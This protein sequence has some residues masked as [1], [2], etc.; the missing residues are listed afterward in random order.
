MV[1]RFDDITEKI[2]AIKE[3]ALTNK[4]LS[5]TEAIKRNVKPGA[6]I[7]IGTTHCCSSAAIWEIARQFHG[8]KPAFTL[9][10]RGIRD[11]VTI[12]FHMGLIKKV[13]TGFS[14]NVYPWYSP[15]PVIQKAY[16]NKEVELEDWSI[17]TFPLMLMAGALGVGFM[18]T[19]SI[20]GSTM[21][22]DNQDSFITID[23]PFGTGEKIG[24][25]KA[26]NPDL[27]I[28]HGL[29][30]D[31]EGNTILTPPYSE[32]L[33]GSK[34][35]TG[36]TVVTVEKLVTTDFIR[37]HSHLVKLPGY[38]VKSV[39]E[40]P[41]GAHPGGVWNQ[42]LEKFEAYSEDYVFMT[43][44]NNICRDP[45]ALDAW[46]AEWV[47]DCQS[48]ET[49]KAKL[50]CDRILLLKGNADRD[51]W[52]Y[53]LEALEG[54]IS[55][56]EA[57]NASEVM[58]IVAAREIKERISRNQYK[59]VLAGAG[60][61]NLAAWVA[62]YN[63]Q[64][65]GYEAE[66]MVELGYYGSAPRPSEPF[67]LNFGNFPTCKMLTET[68]DTLGVFTS[69]A[70][71]RCIGVLGGGQVDKFGNIN[72]TRMSQTVYLTG[73]GGANDVASGAKEV[74]LVMQQSKR[75][76]LKKVPYITASGTRVKTLV[77][78]MG[79]YEKLGDDNEFTLTKYIANPS[80]SSKEDIIRAI[81]ENCDWDIRV[82][83]DLEE[84]SLPT[85]EELRLLRVFDPNRF[86]L[87]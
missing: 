40:V 87:K 48:F 75:R 9:I 32:G 43:E 8:K 18:P 56:N 67:V 22:K 61:A 42:G 11:T 19:K 14:G 35:S 25:L 26:L 63:L 31:R 65:E 83:R 44:F 76:F 71:N 51:A 34:A 6:K 59:T 4:V 24:L 54:T 13:I 1:G 33:W 27:S 7:H 53:R 82:A 12:L 52:K 50:G 46:I 21:A 85:L 20:I 36:G 72:S 79:V 86:Y 68:I 47:L 57:C 80:F 16:V 81:Q 10:M 70:T 5:L 37:Q 2:I 77:S 17:L 58:V 3:N 15:N 62:K 39:S 55:E 23:D 30:A 66:L 74:V 49:Y 60:T 78:S 69:G 45:K 38:M 28:V 73:S 29:A 41:L 84:V 64:N